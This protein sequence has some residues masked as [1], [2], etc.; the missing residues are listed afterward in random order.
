MSPEEEHT[1]LGGDRGGATQR[2]KDDKSTVPCEEALAYRRFEGIFGSCLRFS[3]EKI[4]IS[5]IRISQKPD[6]WAVV[7]N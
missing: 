1:L 4:L 2:C 6:F 5:F 3:A 7:K